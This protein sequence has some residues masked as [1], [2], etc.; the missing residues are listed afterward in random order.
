MEGL[1]SR[2]LPC[3]VSVHLVPI[4]LDFYYGCLLL[5]ENSGSVFLP[6]DSRYVLLLVYSGNT[7]LPVDSGQYF[8]M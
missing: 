5:P 4:I 6:V 3:L 8:L 2:G 7:P 1:L